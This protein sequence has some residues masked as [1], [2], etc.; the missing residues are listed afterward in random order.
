PWLIAAPTLSQLS[1]TR[2]IPSNRE[3]RS[4]NPSWRMP[5]M[6]NVGVPL[7]SAE[8]VLAHARRMHVRIE[9]EEK[10]GEIQPER[11]GV[12]LQIVILERLETVAHDQGKRER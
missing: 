4:Y 2:S 12:L 1:R 5:L 11:D 3:A 7:T 8:E 10:S 6:K 9:L